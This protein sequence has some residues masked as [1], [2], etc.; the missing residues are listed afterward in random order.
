MKLV[1]S[2]VELDW[3][4]QPS[5]VAFN[6]LT[7]RI[8]SLLSLKMINSKKFHFCHLLSKEMRKII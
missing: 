8:F 4:S 1:K 7:Q 3:Y 6:F 5:R 2:Q